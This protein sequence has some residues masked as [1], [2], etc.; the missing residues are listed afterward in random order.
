MMDSS[1]G[2]PSEAA[3]AP[4]LCAKFLTVPLRRAGMAW[5]N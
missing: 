4:D 3:T 1:N 5:A 2:L